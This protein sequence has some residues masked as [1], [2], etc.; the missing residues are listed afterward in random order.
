MQFASRL[1]GALA[2]AFCL[3]CTVSVVADETTKSDES[4]ETVKVSYD[5]Q[6]RPI[7]QE[8]CQGCHQPANARGKYVMTDFT[9]ML[10]GGD[11]GLEAIVPGKP[12][13]SYL[14][15]EITPV[16]GDA[17]MPKGKAPLHETE[18]ALI[19]RWIEQGAENDSPS[20]T[21][22]YDAENPPIYTLAPVVTS[23]EYS[24]NGE[25]LAI[26]GFHEVLLHKADGSAI[27]KRLIGLSERIES[28]G[29]SPDGTKL[30]VTGGSPGRF[31]EVQVWEVAS[32]KLLLSKMV[33]YDTLYG[34]SWSPDGKL[35]AFGC[36][37]NTVRA[38]DAETGEQVLFQGAHSDWVRD[39]VFSKDGSH[40][41]SVA[42]DMTVKLTEVETERFVDNV[43]SIT[44]GVLKGGILSLAR[45]PERDEVV[46]GGSDGVPKVY[47][48]FRQT[49]RRI[50]DDAN[51]IRRLPEMEGRTY[52]V[53]VSRQGNRIAAGSS[54]DGSGQVFVYG[55]EFDT[56]LTDEL[57]K[58][59]SEVES[60]RSAEQRQKLEEYRTAG[61]KLISKVEFPT[62]SIYSV[63][64][65]PEGKTL[66]AAGSDG[67][68]YTV[69]VETGE[70]VK[71]F[72]SVPTT[73]SVERENSLAENSQGRTKPVSRPESSDFKGTLESLLVIPQQIELTGEFDYAQLI[74]TGM[75]TTGDVLDVTRTAGVSSSGLVSIDKFGKVTPL[76]NGEG[77][78]KVVVGNQ[79]VD[80]P[81]IVK[82]LESKTEVDFIQH[83]N[84]VLSRLGCNQ[85]TCHGSLNGKNG[86]KLS[87]RGYDPIYDV[88]A[89]TDDLASRRV[90]IASPDDSL[91]LLKATGKVPH[92]GGKLLDES[93][94]YYRILRRWISSG[95]RLNL[96]SPR[97]ARIE[98]L[99]MNP[100]VQ[101]IGDAQQFRVVA[102]YA[103][104]T[105]RDVTYEA[106]LES[107][108]TEVAKPTANTLMETIRRG[109][110]PMLARFE[111]AYAAT[112]LTVMG[113]RDGFEWKQPET[114]NQIDELTANKWKR[115]KIQ[116]SPLA[117]DAEFIRRVYLDLT[118]LPPSADEVIAFL[119]DETPQREKRDKLIEKL[120]GSEG[121]VDYWT[122]KWA[123]L[124]QVNRKFLGPEGAK[125]F[126][127]WIRKHV[128]EN[129]PYDQFA[130][131]LLTADGSNRENPAASYYKVLREPDA[132][133]E[134]TTHLFLA[135]RFN[136]NK[137]HDHPFERWT[138]DQYYETAAFFARVGLKGDP[139]A[140]NKRIGGT[141]VEGAKPLYEIVYDKQ[142]GEVIHDRTKQVT[143]PAFP[144]EADY[145]DKEDLTRRQELAAWITSADNQYFAK[146]YVNRLWGYM[147]GVGI[148]EPID[149]IR[150]GNPPSNPELLNYLTQ[151][152]VNSGFD[153]QH[154]LKLICESR[155]YQLS[156]ATNKWNE[157]DK[158]NFS[159]ATARRLPAEVLYDAIHKVTGANSKFPGVA[160]G[161]RAAALPDSGVKLPDSFL[162]TFGR[163]S[164]ESACECERSNEV[165]LGGVMALV[166]GP[167]VSD[168]I[169]D[170]KNELTKLVAETED[171]RELINRIFLRALSRPANSAEIDLVLDTLR[172]VERDHEK[173]VAALAQ[174][175]AF[176]KVELPRLQAEQKTAIEQA[177]ADLAAYQAKIK[178]E[179]DKLEAERRTKIENAEKAVAEYRAKLPEHLAAWSK[180]MAANTDW[181]LLKPASFKTT[182]KAKH[183][184]LQDRSILVTGE[185]TPA[186]YTVEFETTL[187][188]LSALR[189]EALP[190]EGLP[191]GGPGL[192]PNGN[193]V[194]TEFEVFVAA[195][196]QPAE[197]TKL[198]L[199]KPKTDFTQSGFD[200]AQTIDGN[201]RDQKG[202]AVSPVGGMVH[203]ATYGIE[204]PVGFDQGTIVRVL[205]HQY[206]NAENH[207]LGRFRIS[208]V[209]GGND[210]GLSLPESLD[211]IVSTK[212]EE[213]TEAQSKLLSQ[214]FEATHQ[215]L[216]D[217]NTKV[218]EAKRPVPE[219]PGVTERKEKIAY[220]SQPIPTDSRLERLRSDIE[221]SKKQLENERLTL[222]QDLTWAL[223]NSPAFL[224]N[225]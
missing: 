91:M 122:N 170:P 123:D 163:P 69:D 74:A 18:I 26:A 205:I 199:V 132:M 36:A 61:V 224:F 78:L 16:D 116:P 14:I 44:P 2:F 68:I 22:T 48:L 189:L 62:T 102:T 82:G 59:M 111:G 27:E 95:A 197:M 86:F 164:R 119:D 66:S 173:V 35:I 42:R 126:R 5:K 113:N 104:G 97:V 96:N 158:L 101:T 139:K 60:R 221:F 92:Q 85:G 159:H 183:E 13:D 109:E 84:P 72:V 57:K 151:E 25:W 12:D 188:D 114:F 103:D 99:P 128:A 210:V 45:H 93:D 1:R 150:A 89:L 94:D 222:V 52:S 180:K 58:I 51:Q 211:A 192:P 133:M 137:C 187:K 63:A 204:K 3:T 21:K 23:L 75:T 98:A 138:Q 105:E 135:V 168:A 77:V 223:V 190:V 81:V 218:A 64:F 165:Q 117:T 176:W 8:H 140:G 50:G 71:Q 144:Y 177:N 136:C 7:F 87:L 39:T 70:I 120:I 174:R 129:T 19:R 171:D 213:R 30:A 148:I 54:L 33:T 11:T 134:N 193:F 200:I 208:A 179:R 127:D 47:R 196:D 67:L 46:I 178:P 115:L 212:T 198:K 215:P 55:Y 142:D 162:A 185:A 147:T 32:G 38:I 172:E 31:G 124:L 107:G 108:N 20:Q 49:V 37:D 4:A 217:L 207:R 15:D 130:R 141:A 155:T 203:W 10:K 152:F 181:H 6:I 76:K 43:T 191:G 53:D 9:R 167:T 194:V 29:F 220:L 186:T 209:Q 121:Y 153:T 17:E 157:D 112:T 40:L 73:D 143:P 90:S 88:R 145:E 100:V 146:S 214:Y 83:V 175:E 65:H 202:W 24:P 219:D 154:V 169:S 225:R 56:S 131:E 195:K 182:N 161:T 201:N 118:G 160:A 216:R 34:G 125:S 80:V 184:R 156:I 79:S 110:A 206:H 166:T 149:D 41:V 106:F 28:V